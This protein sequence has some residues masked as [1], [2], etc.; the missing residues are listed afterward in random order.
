MPRTQKPPQRPEIIDST[1]GHRSTPGGYAGRA[2]PAPEG[3]RNLRSRFAVNFNARVSAVL[4]AM[5]VLSGLSERGRYHYT[6]AEWE[7]GRAAIQAKLDE[8]HT[9]F[10]RGKGPKTFFQLGGS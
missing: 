3:Y 1:P 2:G 9:L 4:K 6:D 5:D 8:L 10:R 7:E